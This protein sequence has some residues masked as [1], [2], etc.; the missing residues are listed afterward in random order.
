MSSGK[1]SAPPTGI[2]LCSVA[3][4]VASGNEVAGDAE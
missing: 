3:L 4:F 1:R 2:L